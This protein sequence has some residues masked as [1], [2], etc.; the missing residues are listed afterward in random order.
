MDQYEEQEH[1][2]Y[3]GEIPDEEGEMDAEF[4][5]TAGAEDYQGNDQGLQQDP[6]SSKVP[7]FHF[8]FFFLFLSFIWAILLMKN[9]V[10]FFFF[11]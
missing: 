6:S 10:F 2:V 1:E 8:S 3:G 9:N 11:N 7:L 4:D 5:M